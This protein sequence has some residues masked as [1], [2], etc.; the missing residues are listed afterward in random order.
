MGGGPDPV[1]LGALLGVVCKSFA[2]PTSG[3]WLTVRSVSGFAGDARLLRVALRDRLAKA[4]DRSGIH[5][6]LAEVLAGDVDV[7]PLPRARQ[8]DVGALAVG[9]PAA[10]EHE[11]RDRPCGPG[12][13]RRA[14]RR[15]GGVRRAPRRPTLTSRSCAPLVWIE[16]LCSVVDLNDA[17]ERAVLDARLARLVDRAVKI[18][19]SPAASP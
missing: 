17:A 15:R 14:G 5:A 18:T 3:A 19:S 13:C 1:V 6:L 11:R 9:L 10:G 12:P 8:R 7:G 2:G 4:F 16:T